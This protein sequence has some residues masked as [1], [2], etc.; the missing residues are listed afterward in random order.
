M[1]LIVVSARDRVKYFCSIFLEAEV[2]Q[3]NIFL[4][5]I[6]GDSEAGAYGLH[7]EKHM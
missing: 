6:P 1:V 3:E 2:P 4:I 5:S 7:F